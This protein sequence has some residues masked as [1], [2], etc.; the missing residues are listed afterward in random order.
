VLTPKGTLVPPSNTRNRWIGGFSRILPAR[1]MAPVVSQRVRAPEMAPNQADLV[2][3][4]E[5]LESGRLTPVIDRTYPLVE[6]PEAIGY[7]EEGHT[8]G[9][10]VITI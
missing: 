5:L 7:F 1:L 4:T 10:I 2:A 3:L 9:K 6:V 8:R